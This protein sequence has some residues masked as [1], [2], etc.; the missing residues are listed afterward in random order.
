MMSSCQS[1][2]IL[3]F[4]QAVRRET[5]IRLSSFRLLDD[6]E[7]GAR[8][9]SDPG[10]NRYVLKLHAD[11]EKAIQFQHVEVTTGRLR[12]LCYP[13]PVHVASGSCSA[14]AWQL[15]EFQVGVADCPLTPAAID[16]LIRHNRLQ[17]RQ[18]PDSNAHWVEQMIH[19]V[20][21]GCDNFCNPESLRDYSSETRELLNA[22]QGFA[23]T[24]TGIRTE[25]SDIVHFDFH[26]GNILT[27]N[28]SVA[29]VIDWTGTCVGDATF[30]LATL[31]YYIYENEPHRVQLSNEILARVE[32]PVLRLYL[33]HIMLRQLNWSIRHHDSATIER[34]LAR[35]QRIVHEIRD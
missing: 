2:Q 25:L 4:A 8:V 28:G 15:I 12:S 33:S 9:A 17:Q 27:R 11:P 14:G 13:I 32:A 30:D 22:I 5:G 6:G 3:P 29:S 19:S 31:L 24:A 34:H 23:R 26:P 21:V 10:G 16:Q 35:S 1:N 20:D 18:A 7:S